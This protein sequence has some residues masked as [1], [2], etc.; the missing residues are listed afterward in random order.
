MPVCQCICTYA[1]SECIMCIVEKW[2]LSERQNFHAFSRTACS[3]PDTKSF[4]SSY[5]TILLFPFVSFH[6][7]PLD[8][9]GQLAPDRH[10]QGFMWRP[11]SQKPFC[12]P[13]WAAWFMVEKQN[14]VHVCWLQSDQEH[15]CRLNIVTT[16]ILPGPAV[17]S[18]V[19]DGWFVELLQVGLWC[20]WPQ[21]VCDTEAGP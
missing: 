5:K 18:E 7:F 11:C 12:S 14:V 15:V 16:D 21:K 9:C 17:R 6:N 8:R 3:D 4:L 20:F 13:G 19:C 2:W 1:C 10:L